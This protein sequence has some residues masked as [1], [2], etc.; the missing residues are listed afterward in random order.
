[1][2]RSAGVARTGSGEGERA[3]R[4]PAAEAREVERLAAQVDWQAILPARAHG[5]AWRAQQAVKRAFDIIVAAAGLLVL[6][7]VFAVISLAVILDSPGAVFYRWR[8][9]G[10]RGR[11]FTGH[12]FRTMVPDADERKSS[13]LHLNEMSGPVFKMREDPRV[14]RLGRFLRRFSLD[15]LPELWSVLKGDM[16]LVGP[17]PLGLGEFI[18]CPP[19]HRQ[20]LSVR[21]GVTCLWQVSGRSDIREFDEWVRLDKEYIRR[22]SLWLDAKIFV[23]TLAVVFRGTG[24][25]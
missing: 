6:L 8:V 7:P 14:T 20:K 13:L 16:T 23:R 1:M 12:K 25:Y 17:R 19:S 2:V 4:S 15:E 18:D 11:S 22:W 21:P 3:E 24:A 10:Y 9:V 5:A